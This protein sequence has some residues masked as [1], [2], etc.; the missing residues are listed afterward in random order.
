MAPTP[1]PQ[2]VVDTDHALDG[3][4]GKAAEKLAAFR[5]KQTLDPAGPRYPVKTYAKAVGRTLSVIQRYAKGYALFIERQENP[6]AGVP[7][8]IQDAIR[9]AEQSAEMQEFSEAIAE[10]S[11]KP[12]SQVARGDN[13]HR[14][15]AIVTR[16]KERAERRGTN[17][18][19]EARDIALSE[20]RA[21]DAAR[22]RDE[23]EKANHG[24]K[25]LA[26]EGH[27]ASAKD[28]LT[29]ALTTAEGVNFTD[30]EMEL[31]RSTIANIRALLDLI[32]LRMAGAPDI[33][34]DGELSKL[35]AS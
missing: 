26:I 29:R 5:W 20:A 15:N 11:G 8:T 25:Y 21:R 35:G 18:V 23:A 24:R 4:A 27:L 31:L 22:A 3:T 6:R 32:D 17:P 7:L 13:R 30:E 33:D 9:L 1:I 34:W 2:V 16:A 19:D 10:G 12:V 14:T 28:R